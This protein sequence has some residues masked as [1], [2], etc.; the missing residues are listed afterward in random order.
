MSLML[1]TEI[2]PP[3]QR[4]LWVELGSVPGSFALYGGTALA[5]RLGHRNS[6]DFDFFSCRDLDLPGLETQVPFLRDARVTQRERNT[7]SVI[8]ERGGPVKVSFFGVPALPRLVQ[9]SWAEEAGIQVAS[10]LDLA[11]TKASVVQVR[12]ESKDYLD[13]DALITQGG[14]GLPAALSAAQGLYGPTFNPQITLKSLSYFDDGDLQR[15]PADVRH[16]LVHAAREVDLDN[17]PDVSKLVKQM[18]RDHGHD[19]AR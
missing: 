5:L 18:S 12:A 3:A 15:L 9:P 2:L 10:L 17:L 1:H 6:I 16:R 7:L 11:G 19:T 14:V 4:R 8:V 13:I